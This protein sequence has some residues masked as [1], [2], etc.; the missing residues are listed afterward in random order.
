MLDAA[1]E[2]FALTAGLT[3]AQF[4]NDRL[5]CLAAEKLFMNLGEA[6]RRMGP[7]TSQIPGVPWRLVI[8]LRNIIAHQYEHIDHEVLYKTVQSELPRAVKALEDWLAGQGH[9]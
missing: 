3:E 2:L 7:A 5:R 8:G 6:A 9:P 4:T 1:G